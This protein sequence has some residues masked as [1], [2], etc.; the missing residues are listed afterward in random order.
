[1]PVT[2][3]LSIRS[4]VDLKRATAA[5]KRGVRSPRLFNPVLP[6]ERARALNGALITS[7]M[8]TRMSD[9]WLIECL[10]DVARWRYIDA[11]MVQAGYVWDDKASVWIRFLTLLDDL[12][13]SPSQSADDLD[14]LRNVWATMRLSKRWAILRVNI[15][16]VDSHMRASLIFAGLANWYRNTLQ[17]TW[18]NDMG[19]RGAFGSDVL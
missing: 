14:S 16:T 17:S 3:N 1:M 8:T 12:W 13:E 9:L 2:T 19:Y 11:F 15:T 4:S 18:W 5:I 10:E 7:R 6:S